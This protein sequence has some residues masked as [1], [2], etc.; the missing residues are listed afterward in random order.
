[1]TYTITVTNTGNVALTGVVISDDIPANTTYV[2]GSASA[3][4]TLNGNTLSWTEDIALGGSVSV[5]FRVKVADDL[6]GIAA[7]TNIAT[8]NGPGTPQ[9]PEAPE[10]PTDPV[11][12][13]TSVKSVT[14]ASGDGRA[15]A[16]EELTYT[17]T[18]TNTGNVAL[19]GINISDDIPANTTYVPGSARTGFTL[20]GNTLS[21]TEDIALGGNVS[22]SFRVKIADD[23][24]G[25]AAITNIAT[26]TG[27]G[28]PQEPEAPE[29]PTDPVSDY[30]SVKSVTDAS[31]DGRA[32][33][34]EELTYTITVTNTGNVALTG[35]VI[36]DDIPANT[37]YVSG[38]A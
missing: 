26:V 19:T 25:I 37:T 18:V 38:S 12:D 31:G 6:T 32:Q 7:I 11:S 3:G 22:V 28:T 36:S 9:E 16:G 24:T 34:G 4:F 15:Q 5:S 29:V 20:Y 13:Y 14:D 1:L 8:V 21:W 35:V 23:L 10:V 27:P 30:T 33:A 2:P 17:I